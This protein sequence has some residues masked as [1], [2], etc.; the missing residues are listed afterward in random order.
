MLESDRDVCCLG[1]ARFAR[2]G[3]TRRRI[4]LPHYFPCP[5]SYAVN[6][7]TTNLYMSRVVREGASYLSPW[8]SSLC[9]LWVAF[10]ELWESCWGLRAGQPA[11]PRGTGSAVPRATCLASAVGGEMGVRWFHVCPQSAEILNRLQTGL[12]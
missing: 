9:G 5:S 3:L 2:I 6:F 4:H 10:L 7:L 1:I 11:W 8:L 12:K